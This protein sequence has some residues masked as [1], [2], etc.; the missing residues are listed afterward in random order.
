MQNNAYEVSIQPWPWYHFQ[1]VYFSRLLHVQM[2]FP[3]QRGESNYKSQLK[4]WCFTNMSFT[5]SCNGLAWSTATEAVVE[6]LDFFFLGEDSLAAPSF[7]M[8]KMIK[9]LLR[10]G[11]LYGREL[12]QKVILIIWSSHSPTTPNP[13]FI[14][15][16]PA[17]AVSAPSRR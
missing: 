3:F 1:L 6:A 4:R 16:V 9:P 13:S 2:Y 15:V 10:F 14:S 7:G 5:P 8:R 17:D 12:N 11:L